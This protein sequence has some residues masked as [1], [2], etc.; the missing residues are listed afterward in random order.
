MH[1]KEVPVL[2]LYM[3]KSSQ[4]LHNTIT[5]IWQN[6]ALQVRKEIINVSFMSVLII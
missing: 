3:T 2:D 5:S 4:I 1:L 6:A